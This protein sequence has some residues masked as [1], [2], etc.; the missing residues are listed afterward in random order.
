MYVHWRAL[1]NS[2]VGGNITPRT[3]RWKS[4]SKY[5]LVGRLRASESQVPQIPGIADISIITGIGIDT[6]SGGGRRDWVGRARTHMPR[7]RN[8]AVGDAKHPLGRYRP[9]S[10]LSCSTL[11]ERAT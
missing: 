6:N 3:S 1:R 7:G 8:F 4:S 11:R 2:Y 5:R 9:L 10:A